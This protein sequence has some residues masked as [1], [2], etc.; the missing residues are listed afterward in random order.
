MTH[1]TADY[2]NAAVRQFDEE[3]NRVG[4]RT[5][6][7]GEHARDWEWS[8]RVGPAGESV[9]ITLDDHYPFSAPLVAL[10]D[11]R[12]RSDWHQTV[13]GVLCL[14]DTHS[15]GD[16]PWLDGARLVR[17]IE[18]WISSAD[19]GW[20]RDAPQLDLEAYNQPRTVTRAGQLVA[21]VLAIEDWNQ[22]AGH[23]FTASQP[24]D[25]GVI[26]LRAV[27]LPPP[28]DPRPHRSR[29][30]RR[31]KVRKAR[32]ERVVNG[33]AVD[34]GE[35]TTP[36]VST[37]ALVEALDGHGPRVLD[38]L[39]AGRPVLVAARYTRSAT[40]GLIGFWLELK[41]D[42]LDRRCLPVAE[43]RSGQQRRAGWQAGAIEDKRVSVI[44]AGS[45]GSYLAD[46]LDRSG[47]R[48]LRVHDWDVLM[49]G[50]L[51]R[52]AASPMFVGAGK[53]TAVRDTATGRNPLSR[54]ETAASVQGL[55][56]A[57]A[58]LRERDLVVDCTGDRLTWQLLLA[59]ADLV[60]VSFLHV[61]VVGHGQFGRVD[62]CPPLDGSAPL[63]EDEIGQVVEG[64]WEGGCGDPVSPT[65][66]SAVVETAAMGARF[67]IRMLAS[68]AVA[69]AGESREL[70][71]VAT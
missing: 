36:L 4:L 20:V 68:E 45:V 60:G 16:Q 59:A 50:N 56:A 13:S 46:I 35:M 48:D 5:Q 39:Q 18:E 21:P 57:V 23:W 51:V 64:E 19:A 54:I 38:L 7:C 63:P 3:M 47:I 9:T 31:G 22:I 2:I 52:H 61:A 49:P 71:R 28:P 29:K 1:S 14:W 40:Q 37:D 65:P 58:L 10:P 11:R 25:R 44:G 27:S 70:F 34:L 6:R 30:A 17:R 12:G 32:T 33:I 62:V 55:D 26:A 67:A 43:R 8:G 41:G 15:K 42:G 69:P 66:P 24:S 53:T